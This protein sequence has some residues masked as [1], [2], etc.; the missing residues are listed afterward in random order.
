M[1][2]GATTDFKNAAAAG[3]TYP[4]LL[5]YFDFTGGIVRLWSGVGDLSWGGNTFTGAGNLVRV[6]PVQETSEVRA[7]GLSFRLNGIPSAMITRIL[8]EGY[9]GRACKLWL[10][11]FDASAALIADPVQLFSG[12]MDQCL[13]EETG[14]TVALTVAAESRLVDLQRARERRR[15]DEDQKSLFAGDRGFE[16]VAGLQDKEVVWGGGTSGTNGVNASAASGG[17][18]GNGGFIGGVSPYEP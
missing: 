6:E 17:G 2:R 18:G 15:T 1:T 4:A 12:R 5:G 14:D 9:R 10:A 8:A 3:N 16:Y 7:N 13:L 11:L